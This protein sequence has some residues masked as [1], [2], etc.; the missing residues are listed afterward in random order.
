[1]TSSNTDTKLQI[2]SLLEQFSRARAALIAAAS[3]VPPALRD[4][5]FVG[6]WDV[7]DVIAHTIGW[8]YTNIEALPDFRAGRLPAFF[9]RYDEDWAAINAALI[10]R[11]RVEDWAALIAAL[12]QSGALF[13]Q[14]MRGLTDADLDT[15]ASWGKRRVSLRGMIRAVSRDE[16]QHVT[17]VRDFVAQS[18]ADRKRISG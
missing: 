7:K 6:A 18:T 15:A 1:M 14:A 2:E 17:Q 9:A 10:A 12:R 16:S 13:V 11:Y 8:D 5:P 4:Q 3:S